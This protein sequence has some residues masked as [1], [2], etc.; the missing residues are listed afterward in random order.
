MYDKVHWPERYDP[1]KSAL[2]ALNDIDVS[3]PAAMVWKLLVDAEHWSTYFPPEDQV[4]I[5]GGESELAPRRA[6]PLPPGLGRT[7]SPSRPGERLITRLGRMPR[8]AARGRPG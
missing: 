7:P 2:Y 3:A 1:R 5:G 6:L 4:K 8:R